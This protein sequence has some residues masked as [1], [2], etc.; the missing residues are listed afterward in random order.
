[1]DEWRDSQSIEIDSKRV[2][3]IVCTRYL[4]L[5]VLNRNDDWYYQPHGQ[6]LLAC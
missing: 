3:K 2:I 4:I 1:M 5:N 6:T